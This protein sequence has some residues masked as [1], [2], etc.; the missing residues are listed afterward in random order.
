MRIRLADE[1][2]E[3]LGIEQEWIEAF[4]PTRFMLADAEALED[5]GYDPDEFLEDLGG[6]PI[7]RDGEPVMDPELDDDG[8]QVLVDGKPKLVERRRIATRTRRALLWLAVR[9]AGSKVS[10][11]DFDIQLNELRYEAEDEA[12]AGKVDTA[13]RPSR[14]RVTA[15][16]SRSSKSSASSRGNSTS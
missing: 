1:D 7:I 4:S 5:A 13:A 2:R 3:R 9:R 15:T 8:N 12:P 6:R 14:K 11:A 10:F 16:G